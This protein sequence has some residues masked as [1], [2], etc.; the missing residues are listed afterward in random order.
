MQTPA[1]KE[2]SPLLSSKLPKLLSSHVLLCSPSCVLISSQIGAFSASW[3]HRD[4]FCLCYSCLLEYISPSCHFTCHLS[5]S[6][7]LLSFPW[8]PSPR[9]KAVLNSHSL[10]IELRL[11]LNLCCLWLVC[12]SLC[13]G[14]ALRANPCAGFIVTFCPGSLTEP[15][16]TTGLT[17][18]QTLWKAC[19]TPDYSV[20]GSENGFLH[21][22]TS[23]AFWST[24]QG[25]CKIWF[26]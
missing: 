22:I 6:P 18:P 9:W 14:R 21:L 4:I 7:T 1:A 16:V 8:H 19:K 24:D 17:P 10:A 23:S 11:S 3:F 20:G 26:F 5:T 15:L 12:L 2:L 13:T 25:G